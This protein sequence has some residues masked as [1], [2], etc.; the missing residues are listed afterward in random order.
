MLTY[1]TV[2]FWTSCSTIKNKQDNFTFIIL[3]IK[4]TASI[5]NF[6]QRNSIQ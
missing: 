1:V 6:I 5:L 4:C 2:S 3:L